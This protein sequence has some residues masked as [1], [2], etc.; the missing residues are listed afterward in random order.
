MTVFA[1]TGIN[2]G[3]ESNVVTVYGYDNSD[4]LT[5]EGI[6][7]DWPFKGPRT[8]F[9]DEYIKAMVIF[10]GYLDHEQVKPSNARELFRFIE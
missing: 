3:M 7:E 1:T 6:I 8:A 2:R 10:Q 5:F 9:Y 4:R